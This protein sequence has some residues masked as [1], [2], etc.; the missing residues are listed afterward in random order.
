MH[1]KPLICLW[2]VVVVVVT[3]SLHP[4][5]YSVTNIFQANSVSRSLVQERTKYENTA[6]FA[7]NL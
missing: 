6:K 1:W 3:W 5:H 2:S 4:H 7:D